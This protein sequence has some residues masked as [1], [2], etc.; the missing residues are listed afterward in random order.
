[1]VDL[2]MRDHYLVQ[3]EGGRYRFRFPFIQRFWQFKRGLLS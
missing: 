1:M 3:D 2:L